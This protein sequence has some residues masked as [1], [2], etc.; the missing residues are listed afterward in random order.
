M[1]CL[2]THRGQSGFEQGLVEVR[3]LKGSL[4]LPH[5]LSLLGSPTL[6]SYFLPLSSTLSAPPLSFCHP[7]A[8]PH[9]TFH[10]PPPPPHLQLITL[11]QRGLGMAAL[12]EHCVTAAHS[13]G[14]PHEL[15][16][17]HRNS[18][19]LNVTPADI[20]KS[21]RCIMLKMLLCMST[22]GDAA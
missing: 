3:A 11:S 16:P 19:S 5:H 17:L 9:N 8:L 21:G 7:S 18:C 10:S 6:S 12:E 20:L 15:P 14:K 4:V 22:R 1:M 2:L 13:C